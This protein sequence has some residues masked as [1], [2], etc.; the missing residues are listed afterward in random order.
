MR[1]YAGAVCCVGRS[2]GAW[3]D[4]LIP[5]TESGNCWNRCCHRP[6]RAVGRSRIPD[7]RSFNAIRY[8]LRT[9]CS[10]RMLPHDRRPGASSSITSAPGGR[11]EVGSVSH[12]TLHAIAATGSGPRIQPSAAIML[13]TGCSWRWWCIRPI[14]RACPVPRHGDRDGARL[15]LAQPMDRFPR[16]R[17]I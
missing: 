3:N 4:L 13:R 12:D 1:G 9:G 5:A 7:G 15:V 17:L 2:V 14:F 10:W 6:N 16:L 8:V 11:M